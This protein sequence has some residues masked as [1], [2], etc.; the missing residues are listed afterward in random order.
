MIGSLAL[1]AVL[2]AGAVLAQGPAFEVP[3]TNSKAVVRQRV[4]A[5][6]IEVTYNRPSVRGRVIF[7]ALVPY[8][9]VW[10]TGSDAATRISFST[11]VTV[12]GAPIDAGTYELFSIP[13]EREWVVIIHQDRSQW[14]SYSYDPAYDVARVTAQPVALH[15]RVETF[16]VSLDEVTTNEATLNIAWDRI[17]VPVRIAID[18]EA[19]VVP[20]LEAALQAEGRR[21]YFLAAMFYFENDLDIERAAEL[22]ALAVEANP[23]HIGMLYRQAL[24]LERKGDLPGAIAA[25]ERSLSGA[26]SASRE[27]R[28]EYTRLNTALLARLRSAGAG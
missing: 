15:D 17:R 25:A 14:G 7:G 27:L 19:T 5:T 20:Q 12:N 4:A 2:A 23:T 16:T 10:R 1:A 18:I 13:G 8:G 9:E 24:I 21:P 26:A 11:P 3:T 22:M 28:D 6:D